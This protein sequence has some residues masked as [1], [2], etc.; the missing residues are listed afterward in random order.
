MGGCIDWAALD[1]IVELYGIEDVP[2]FI[3]QLDEIRRH[4]AKRSNG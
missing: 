2:L 3:S 4:M 1:I